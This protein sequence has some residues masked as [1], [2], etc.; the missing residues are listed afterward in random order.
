MQ[1][2][3][4]KKR[5]GKVVRFDISK[6]RQSVRRAA[7]DAGASQDISGKVSMLAAQRIGKGGKKIAEAEDVKD[8]VENALIELN[9]PETAKEYMLHRYRRMESESPKK[10]FGVTDKLNLDLNALRVL[11]KRY[12]KKDQ[13]GRIVE[14]PRQL[15]RRVA[16]AVAKVDKRYSM[17]AEKA[18]KEFFKAMVNLD[19]LPN[20]PTLMNAGT[21]L[22]QLSAC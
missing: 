10:F 5:D 4:F 2:S 21:R 8:Q 12:L 7:Q 18:Q 13:E 14:T 15:F 3:K 6:I 22:G 16:K 17:D 11:E 19:F 1:V 20:S 9:Q